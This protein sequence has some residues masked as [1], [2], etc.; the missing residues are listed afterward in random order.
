ML[1]LERNGF[2]VR[3]KRLEQQRFHWHRAS[4][5]PLTLDGL[6]LNSLLDRID[7]WRQ[8]PHKTLSF[9]AVM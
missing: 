5:E 6:T 1:Y 9:D 2:I 8:K 3:H 4:D 7:I